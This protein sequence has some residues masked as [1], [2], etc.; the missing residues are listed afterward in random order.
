[1][2]HRMQGVIGEGDYMREF[3]KSVN[4]Y[5]LAMSLFGLKQF[6]NLLTPSERGERKG[7]ATQAM[8]HITSATRE[9]FGPTLDSTFKTLDAFQRSMT[10]VTLFMMFPFLMLAGSDGG[11]RRRPVDREY[12]AEPRE[13]PS[14]RPRA[15]GPPKVAVGRKY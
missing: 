10:D 6:Q 12:E 1:M 14:A 9:E 5:T 7:P 11:S 13:T 3:I 15:A 2:A 8:D 4:S